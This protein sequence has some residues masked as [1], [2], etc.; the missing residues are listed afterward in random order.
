MVGT[1]K[2]HRCEILADDDDEFLTCCGCQ[3]DFCKSCVPGTKR[4]KA[5]YYVGSQAFFCS[6]TCQEEASQW[7]NKKRR[8][9]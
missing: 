1:S 8:L 9:N 2:C 5:A 6:F 4:T 7:P 3:N